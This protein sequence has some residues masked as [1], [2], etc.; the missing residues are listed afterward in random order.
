[1][2]MNLVPS[3][4]TTVL[5]LLLGV[6]LITESPVLTRALYCKAHGMQAALESVLGIG[7]SFTFLSSSAAAL[8]DHPFKPVLLSS[9]TDQHEVQTVFGLAPCCCRSPS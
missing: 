8:P 7:T 5:L 1:M 9:I 3:F 2:K 6:K 4:S